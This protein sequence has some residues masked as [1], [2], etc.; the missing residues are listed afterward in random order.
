VAKEYDPMII[1]LFLISGHYRKSINYSLDNMAQAKKNY[2]RLVNT[3][4]TINDTPSIKENR[5]YID[6]LILKIEN[7]ETKVIEA[8]DDDFNTPVAIAEVMTLFRDL[9]RVVIEEKKVINEKFKDRFFKFVRDIDKIFGIFPNLEDQLKGIVGVADEKDKM[10]NGLIEILKETRSKL[11][12][13]KL[14]EI[15]DYI[16]KKLRELGIKVEDS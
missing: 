15:S 3:I 11:R 6:A 14:F 9:N 5:D 4:Q 7:A 1:R 2:E 8:M 10:I 16:R 13:Q 12:A